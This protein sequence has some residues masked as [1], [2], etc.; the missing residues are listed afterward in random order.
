MTTAEERRAKAELERVSAVRIQA[1]VR[2]CMGR[3]EV[4]E[5]IGQL[6]ERVMEIQRHAETEAEMEEEEDEDMD[7][8]KSERAIHRSSMRT[9]SLL[10]HWSVHALDLSVGSSSSSSLA[11]FG[12]DD[13]DDFLEKKPH[14]ST[15]EK[16]ESGMPNRRDIAASAASAAL[17]RSQDFESKN[18]QISAFNE[19]LIEIHCHRC[20]SNLGKVYEET[21]TGQDGTTKYKERH[22]V[23][24]RALK[25][26]ED[27]LPRRTRIDS[28]LLFASISQA[29]LLGLKAAEPTRKEPEFMRARKSVAFVSPRS[30]KNK[31]TSGTRPGVGMVTFQSPER[32]PRK[33][34]TSNQKSIN[35]FFLSKS[36]H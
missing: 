27:N 2:G 22:C 25:Y 18:S 1:F 5:K 8:D 17:K 12:Y 3:A 21:S 35:A 15:S 11:S 9:F 10:G 7:V 6:I 29:R 19:L 24:G 20:K 13:D 16:N 23:N 4:S 30:H 34:M 36:V 32:S 14:K 28:S 26:V 31:V 33:S